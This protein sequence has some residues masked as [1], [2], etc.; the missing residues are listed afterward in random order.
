VALGTALVASGTVYPGCVGKKT[1]EETHRDELIAY[2][3]LVR[4]KIEELLGVENY[5]RCCT[6]MLSEYDEFAPHLPTFEDDKNRDQFY[7]NAP[8]M[9]SLYRTLLGEFACSQDRA[10]DLLSQITCSKVRRDYE[11]SHRIEKFFFR[12][13]AKS[14]FLRDVVLEKIKEYKDEKFGWEIKFPESDVYMAFDFTRCGLVDWFKDQ[15]VP[16]IAPIACEGDFIVAEYFTGLEFVRTKTIASGDEI[17]DFR[18][19]KKSA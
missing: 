1:K 10:L 16:E 8:F 9:L 6:A 13:L 14:E 19:V 17:C 7:H 18:Y 15:E 3:S 2:Q 5:D 12:R 11:E 4:A